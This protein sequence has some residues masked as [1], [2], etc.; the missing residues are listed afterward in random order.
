M[1]W[2]SEEGQGIVRQRS[3]PGDL[4]RSKG[5]CLILPYEEK[6]SSSGCF[7]GIA[8]EHAMLQ[9]PMGL[10]GAPSCLWIPIWKFSPEGSHVQGNVVKV[11]SQMGGGDGAQT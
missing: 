7:S 6:T 9:V 1:K 10:S 8:N 11:Q 2:G 4:S 5:S 3:Q